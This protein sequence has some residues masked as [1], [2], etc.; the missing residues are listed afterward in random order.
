MVDKEKGFM[1]IRSITLST[2]H[3]HLKVIDGA[4]LS[5]HLPPQPLA[6][7]T[8]PEERKLQNSSTKSAFLEDLGFSEPVL[9]Q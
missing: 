8:S 6:A 4:I 5:L 9:L 7:P 3:I 2:D 1:D